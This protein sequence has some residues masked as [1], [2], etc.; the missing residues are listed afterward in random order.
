[1]QFYKCRITAFT[2]G[3]YSSTIT[4]VWLAPAVSIALAGSW[5]S[6]L[7]HRNISATK[8]TQT[9]LLRSPCCSSSHRFCC[10]P[11]HCPLNLLSCLRRY[12]F[13]FMTHLTPRTPCHQRTSMF[14]SIFSCSSEDDH[15]YFCRG[16]RASVSCTQCPGEW[17]ILRWCYLLEQ[18][19][20]PIQCIL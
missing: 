13:H 6:E 16:Y 19:L 3:F 10:F 4:L 11:P 12:R 8:K 14:V 17:P 18:K 1:M 9:L 7:T 5:I 15:L 2:A 20:I